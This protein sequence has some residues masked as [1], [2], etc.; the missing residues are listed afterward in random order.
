MMY[1]W[2]KCHVGYERT[3]NYQ[4]LNQIIINHVIILEIEF[5]NDGLQYQNKWI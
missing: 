3:I 2:Y 4:A 5:C 1:V